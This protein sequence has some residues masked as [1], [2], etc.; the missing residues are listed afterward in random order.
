MGCLFLIFWENWPCFN[1]TALY[2]LSKMIPVWDIWYQQ[3]QLQV[4]ALLHRFPN[5]TGRTQSTFWK[6]GSVQFKYTLRGKRN[7]KASD[8]PSFRGI[9]GIHDDV[10]K[11]K[12]FQRYWPFERGIHRSRWI[13]H[14]KASDQELYVFFDLR[15]N[16][17]WRKQPWGW[18]FET[19]S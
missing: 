15:L 12:C 9:G 8:S 19:P 6:S 13:P 5:S 3:L 18:W 14:T 7:R 1:G 16:K 10:I 11:W 4:V 17:R 2:I